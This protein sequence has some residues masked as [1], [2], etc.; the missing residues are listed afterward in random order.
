MRRS[1]RCS[2]SIS[3]IATL[4]TSRPDS[5]RPSL[6]VTQTRL[7][8]GSASLLQS[9]THGEKISCGCS[10][11]A[12]PAAAA[13]GC[14]GCGRRAALAAWLRLRLSAPAAAAVGGGGCCAGG[15]GRGDDREQGRRRDR[16]KHP[17]DCPRGRGH[18]PINHQL[19]PLSR[20]SP[21]RW[22]VRAPPRPVSTPKKRQERDA[23]CGLISRI[24]APR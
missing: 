5:T 15:V 1:L 20:R 10:P 23:G 4:T 12:A 19:V 7:A 3:M 16:G 21:R 17:A 24:R 22:P 8:L 18:D 11:A 14:A 6:T 2:P 9:L 13:R